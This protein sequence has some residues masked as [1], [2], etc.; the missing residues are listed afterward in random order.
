MIRLDIAVLFV[1]DE[2]EAGSPARGARRLLHH[3]RL[4]GCPW[5][6]YAWRRSISTASVSW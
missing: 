6:W 3:A 4:R 5:C 2:A 1:G